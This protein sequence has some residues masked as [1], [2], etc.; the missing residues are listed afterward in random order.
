MP[1]QTSSMPDTIYAVFIVQVEGYVTDETTT[2]EIFTIDVDPC[3]GVET[4]RSWGNAVPRLNARKGFWEFR[5][6]DAS[7]SPY[8]REVIHP[9]DV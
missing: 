1:F 7:L 4:E 9:S 3:T 5:S 8:T 6:K 2:I